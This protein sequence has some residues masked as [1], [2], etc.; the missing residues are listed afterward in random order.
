MDIAGKLPPSRLKKAPRRVQ[1]G[2]CG[3]KQKWAVT[4][5]GPFVRLTF[6]ELEPLAGALLAVLLPLVRPRIACQKAE[7]FQPGPQLRVEL[8]QGPCHAKTCRAR[9]PRDSTA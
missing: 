4:G 2:I 5:P 8:H 1:S 3:R 6:G 7:L 9:L